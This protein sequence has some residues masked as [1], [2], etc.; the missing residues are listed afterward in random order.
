MIE[1]MVTAVTGF[2]RGLLMT[3]ETVLGSGFAYTE[4]AGLFDITVAG[5]QITF[6]VTAERHIFDLWEHGT[7][8]F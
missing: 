2:A 6:G 1:M 8:F 4:N 7:D 3:V 5:K